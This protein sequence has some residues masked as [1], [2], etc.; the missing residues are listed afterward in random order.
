MKFRILL[1]LMLMLFSASVATAASFPDEDG[2]DLWLRYRPVEAAYARNLHV[3][4]ILGGDTPLQ[5]SAE[6]ELQR[7]LKGLLGRNAARV[8]TVQAGALILGT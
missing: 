6:S 8:K 7:G 5:R 3:S 1:S 4:A 2:Y